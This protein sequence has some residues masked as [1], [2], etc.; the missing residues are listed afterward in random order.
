MGGSAPADPRYRRPILGRLRFMIS[1]LALVDLVAIVPAFIPG[2]SLDLRTARVLRLLRISRILKLGRYSKSLRLFAKVFVRAWP[3]MVSC[4]IVL[5]VPLLG[6]GFFALP[7]GII[8]SNYLGAVRELD[9][10]G[11]TCPLWPDDAT[12]VLT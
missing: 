8:T 9:D 4:L 1:P 3:E 12:L 7:A 6:I 11:E 5:A 2:V 10:E